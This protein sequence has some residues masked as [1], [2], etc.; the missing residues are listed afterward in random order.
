MDIL[1]DSKKVKTVVF[2]VDG[3]M[4]DKY[5][6]YNPGM[7]TVADAQDYFRF[8]AYN[9]IKNLN[10]DP[11]IVAKRL[12]FC[13][14]RFCGQRAWLKREVSEID[15]WLKDE[16]SGLLKKYKR[17]GKIFVE[18]FNL[19]DKNFLHNKMFRHINFSHI[20]RPREELDNVLTY[21]NSLGLRIGILTTEVYET[22]QGVFDA[23][24][25][26]ISFFKME[27]GDDFPILCSENIKDCK[28]GAEGF[29]R[30]KDIYLNNGESSQN[31]LYVG[32]NFIK[33]IEPSLKSGLQAVHITQN[34]FPGE[35]S[36]ITLAGE[37][38][39]YVQI[40]KIDDLLNFF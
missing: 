29:E 19:S 35:D 1:F 39:H 16:Y 28:P 13:Y 5:T 18:E 21:L 9:M 36:Y 17:N 40:K 26:Q 12:V 22:I 6:E 30:L 15:F 24:D 14:K 2:D 7:G 11:D 3:T 25:I 27:T 4:Y 37:K 32:D 20:L 8:N 33:D 10:W 31:I 38:H 34:H 23:M